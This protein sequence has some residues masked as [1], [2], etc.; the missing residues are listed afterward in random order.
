MLMLTNGTPTKVKDHPN[1]DHPPIKNTLLCPNML[2][3]LQSTPEISQRG[4]IVAS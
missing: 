2:L 3:K 4:S 1:D